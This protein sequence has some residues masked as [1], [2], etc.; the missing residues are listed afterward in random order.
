M[1]F[2]L[3][4]KIFYTVFALFVFMATLFLTMFTMFYAEKYSNDFHNVSKRNQYVMSLLY[5]NIVL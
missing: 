1:Y 2:S 5:D 4:K 3:K